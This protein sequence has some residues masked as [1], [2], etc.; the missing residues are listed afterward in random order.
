MKENMKMD[1]NKE[2]EKL[3][4]KIKVLTRD[5]LNLIKK[6]DSVKISQ[7]KIKLKL[8]YKENILFLLKI[9]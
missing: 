6:M 4:I 7:K 2:K 1:L 9:L 5:S 3:H 8:K